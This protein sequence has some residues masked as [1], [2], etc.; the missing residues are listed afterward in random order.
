MCSEVLTLVER[1]EITQRGVIRSLSLA[2]LLGRLRL[3]S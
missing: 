1:S 3:S 2:K